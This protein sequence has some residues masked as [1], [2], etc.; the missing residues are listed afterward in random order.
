MLLVLKKFLNCLLKPAEN[1]REMRIRN[2]RTG[3]FPY[4]RNLEP[5]T[6]P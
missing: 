3:M 1:G 5:V 2:S 6:A 4:F